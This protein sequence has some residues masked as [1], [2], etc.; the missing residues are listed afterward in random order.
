MTP[1]ILALITLIQFTILPIPMILMDAVSSHPG[2]QPSDDVDHWG[3]KLELNYSFDLETF[4]GFL[5]PIWNNRQATNPLTLVF[6]GVSV[7][8]ND[9]MLTETYDNFS[10]MIC[11]RHPSQ[12][13]MNWLSNEVSPFGLP[14]TWTAGLFISRKTKEPFWGLYLTELSFITKAQRRPI[15][16]STIGQSLKALLYTSTELMISPTISVSAGYRFTDES[17]AFGIAAK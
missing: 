10:F 14:L 16:S 17:S 3:I 11:R 12:K 15:P 6:D 2:R 5:A 8:S 7:A 1:A 13:S 9:Y 4:S